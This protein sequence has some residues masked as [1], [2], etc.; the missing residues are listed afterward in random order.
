MPSFK[1]AYLIHGDDHG[2]IAERRAKL[3]AVAEAT[4]GPGGVEVVEAD[5]PA[6]LTVTKGPYEPRYPSLKGIMAAKK[7]PLEEKPAAAVPSRLKVDRIEAPPERPAGRS[8]AL[9]PSG[10][11]SGPRCARPRMPRVPRVG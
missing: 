5:L 2:R 10:R 6:V 8:G 7:K 1:P 4:S 9:L 3:R 11:A